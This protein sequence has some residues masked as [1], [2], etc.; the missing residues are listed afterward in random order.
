[1]STHSNQKYNPYSY[2]AYK[3]AIDSWDT[4]VYQS[5]PE[6]FQETI[7]IAPSKTTSKNLK[8]ICKFALSLPGSIAVVDWKG[9]G[10]GCL[11]VT[12][13]YTRLFKVINFLLSDILVCAWTR[14]HHI[15]ILVRLNRSTT[16]QDH[17][18][19]SWLPT[20]HQNI[21]SPKLTWPLKMDGW[22]MNFLLG[23]PGLF[24]RAILV[25]GR[26]YYP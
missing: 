22:K 2:D 8:M 17:F 18:F 10:D 12:T 21:P 15:R 19:C 11:Q 1:M 4:K 25:L 7:R 3:Y 6:C 16:S 13:D 23:R 24:P 20:S 9:K 14:D 5:H 26:A